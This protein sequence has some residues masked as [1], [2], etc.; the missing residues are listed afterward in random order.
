MPLI[1]FPLHPATESERIN[2]IKDT[3]LYGHFGREAVFKSLWNKGYWWP[4]IRK[5]IEIELK[6]CDACT[7]FVVVKQGFHPA[8]FITANGPCEHIQI[9][10]SVHLPTSPEGFTALLV[11]IDVFTGFVVL[12]P[13]KDTKAE[14]IAN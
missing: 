5:E 4:Q 12:T 3:H 11:C 7:R 2:L 9:D 10:T 14:T 13:V 6:N 8:Q 1:S